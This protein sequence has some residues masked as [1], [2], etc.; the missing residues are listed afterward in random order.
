VYEFR[1][2]DHQL[3]VVGDVAVATFRYDMIYERA[4]KRSRST[5]RDLW[6]LQAQAGNWIAVWRAMLEMEEQAA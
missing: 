2:H 1:E 3:S 4:G 6:V 5:G